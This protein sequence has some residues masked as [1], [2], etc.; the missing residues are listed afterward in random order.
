MSESNKYLIKQ[1][2]RQK[3][4]VTFDRIPFKEADKAYELSQTTYPVLLLETKTNGGAGALFAIGRVTEATVIEEAV[5]FD[6]MKG[7][8]T[9]HVPFRYEFVLDNKKDGLTREDLQE[10]TGRKFAPQA[11]GGLYEIE[12]SE[13][14]QFSALLKERANGAAETAVPAPKAA[15]PAKQTSSAANTGLADALAGVK[16]TL[17][18]QPELRVVLEDGKASYFPALLLEATTDLVELQTK[19]NDYVATGGN[20]EI[21]AAAREAAATGIAATR[22]A[23]V[24]GLAEQLVREGKYAQAQVPTLQK[25]FYNE[26][27]L[28]NPYL[29]IELKGERGHHVLGADG[30]LYTADG[31]TVQHY[32]GL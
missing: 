26:A 31:K 23:N 22:Y 11:K 28:P 15:K 6:G 21:D 5:E 13:F 3:G 16:A 2:W 29:A 18:K 7:A 24:V 27:K 4:D 1:V 19:I 10:M 32:L 17:T 25:A 9:Y 14:E 30:T 20:A 12:E 8:Y